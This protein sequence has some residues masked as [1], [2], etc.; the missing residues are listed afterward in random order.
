[1]TIISKF[2]TLNKYRLYQNKEVEITR[3]RE[4]ERERGKSVSLYIRK[5]YR[6]SKFKL[7]TSLVICYR[8]IIK[9]LFS[10]VNVQ[11]IQ[12]DR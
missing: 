2:S 9:I 12:T 7:I 8:S 6:V 5:N 1:M 11:D 10:F 3:E 4:R